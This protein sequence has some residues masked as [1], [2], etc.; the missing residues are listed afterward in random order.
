MRFW[1]ESYDESEWLDLS[2][3][4]IEDVCYVIDMKS[5]L[6]KEVIEK[7]CLDEF[8][9]KYKYKYVDVFL[10]IIRDDEEDD[11]L[12]CLKV[13]NFEVNECLDISLNYDIIFNL[14]KRDYKLI[15]I[16]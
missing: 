8:F 1:L 5:Y 14:V 12:C 4:Q 16:Y 2:I 15:V 6:F 9:I 11:Y 3:C 7:M 13:G 10:V